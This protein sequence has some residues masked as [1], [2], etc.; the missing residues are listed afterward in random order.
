MA[1][2][3]AGAGIA[4]LEK[5]HALLKAS[6]GLADKRITDFE[7][8]LPIYAPELWPEVGDGMKG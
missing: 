8:L 6:L 1:H 3:A 7:E 2:S 4:E 5:S